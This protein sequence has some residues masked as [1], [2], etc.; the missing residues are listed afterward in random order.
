VGAEWA[1]LRAI[2]SLNGDMQASIWVTWIDLFDFLFGLL[3][4][5]RTRSVYRGYALAQMQFPI[6]R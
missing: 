5:A 6:A 4:A 1:G 2:K 3:S